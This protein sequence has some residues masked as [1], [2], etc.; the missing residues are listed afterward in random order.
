MLNALSCLSVM[1]RLILTLSTTGEQ[2]NAVDVQI[3]VWVNKSLLPL[4]EMN[5]EQCILCP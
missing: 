1:M 2:W 3:S 4:W 5:S